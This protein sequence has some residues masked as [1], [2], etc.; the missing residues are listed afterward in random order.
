MSRAVADTGLVNDTLLAF[1]Y[2]KGLGRARAPAKMKTL[3]F[4]FVVLLVVFPASTGL[5]GGAAYAASDYALATYPASEQ[6]NPIV[7]IPGAYG[8]RLRDKDSKREIW[9]GPFTGFMFGR[10]SSLAFEIDATTL[11][12]VTTNVE[13]YAL[14]DGFAGVH[15]FRPVMRALEDTAGYHPGTLGEHHSANDH[16][17]YIFLYDWRR[18]LVESAARL[19]RFIEQV[20]KDYGDPNLKVDI[21]AYSAGGL[22]TRYFLLY[23]GKDVLADERVA[24]DN[25]GA[26]KIGHILFVATPNLGS[27]TAVRMFAN[28]RRF[29]GGRIDPEIFATMPAAY[30]MLPH[31]QRDWVVTL[32]GERVNPDLYSVQS[33]RYWQWSVFDPKVRQRI[34]KRFASPK[35]AARYLELLERF[36]AR[37]LVRGRRFHEAI[38]QPLPLASANYDLFGS[39]CKL[40]SA[41]Y[42]L[43]AVKDRTQIR[44]S[45]SQIAHARSDVD[46][47]NLM[48]ERGDG[49][50]TRSSLLAVLATRPSPAGRQAFTPSRWA[51]ACAKHGRLTETRSFRYQLNNLLFFQDTRASYPVRQ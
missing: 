16:R 28:G 19:D 27:V 41:R 22:I 12:P 7:L 24:P 33:W 45:P 46:Y 39:D 17:Y 3:S 35:E 13:P 25:G 21:I 47:G 36:F 30:Q 10:L 15:P 23:G 44:R 2:D 31:P 50:V 40:T 34:S 8:S 11:R 51:F 9:P 43:Q 20:R 38:S 6:H 26:K 49:R 5:G 1:G 29:V 32:A 37:S 48:F 42:L 14:L 4:F 18:D